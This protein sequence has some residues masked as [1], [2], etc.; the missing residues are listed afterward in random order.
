MSGKAKAKR[1]PGIEYEFDIPVSAWRHFLRIDGPDAGR[2]L[3]RWLAG[4]IAEWGQAHGMTLSL[5]LVSMSGGFSRNMDLNDWPVR[6]RFPSK[7]AAAQF[8]LEMSDT[9]SNPRAVA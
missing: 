7:R 4:N 1:A 6:I 5:R 9:F 3:K 2:A 8:Y